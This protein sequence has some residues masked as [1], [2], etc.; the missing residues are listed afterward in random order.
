MKR[1]WVRAS[2]RNIGL[3]KQL[4]QAILHRAAAA[5]HAFIRLDTLSRMTTAIALYR[6]LGFYE[7]PPYYKTPLSGSIY[8]EKGL[9][10]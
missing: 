2:F 9:S 3:G 4:T 1:L 10:P 5:G 6:E 8:L 7:I